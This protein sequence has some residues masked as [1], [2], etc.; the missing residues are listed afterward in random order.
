MPLPTR[1]PP[2]QG[3]WGAPR[4][5]VGRAAR[6]GSKGGRPAEDL[7]VQQESPPERE[8]PAADAENS[9]LERYANW[10]WI[11]IFAVL[12]VLFILGYN[13]IRTIFDWY[14]ELTAATLRFADWLLKE[15]GYVAVFLV[16]LMENA[17]FLGLIVPGSVVLIFAGLGAQE[18]LIDWYIA[19]PLAIAGAIVGDTL[20]YLAGR[21]GWI[22]IFGDERVERWRV[23]WRDRFIENA[24]WVILLYHFL[25]YTRLVGPTAAGVL[26]MPYRRWAPLDYAG[27]AIWVTSFAAV[28]YVLGLLGLGLDDSDRNVQIFEAIIIL[29]VVVWIGRS[30]FKNAGDKSTEVDSE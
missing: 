14:G 7:T 29:M 17:F 18:G 10:I 5:D 12:G 3:L 16:P 27:V 1:N 26:H 25:G 22:R 15:Y 9:W 21:Y 19:L 28:G 30:A 20:S 6:V 23:K 8:D 13:P 11:G 24:T 4:K 2:L